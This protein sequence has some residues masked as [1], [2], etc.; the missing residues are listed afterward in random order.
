MSLASAAERE[1][2]VDRSYEAR[3]EAVAS[4]VDAPVHAAEAVSHDARRAVVNH[5]GEVDASL[6]LAAPASGRLHDELLGYDV[7]WFMRH[8]PFQLG[9]IGGRSSRTGRRRSPSWP[10]AARTARRRS[11]SRASLQ[12]QPRRQ[13][14]S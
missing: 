9:F 5:A 12:T 10:S 6:L 1:T 8:A 3:D 11:P 7:D 4:D 2:D 13:C 14:D